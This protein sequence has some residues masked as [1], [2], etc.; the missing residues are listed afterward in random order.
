MQSPSGTQ[1]AGAPT[2]PLSRCQGG[3][4]AQQQSLCLAC[5]RSQVPS[6]ATSPQRKGPGRRGGEGREAQG[7]PEQTEPALRGPI[8]HKAA[9]QVRSPP[10][11]QEHPPPL[12]PQHQ[13]EALGPPSSPQERGPEEA[14]EAHRAPPCKKT[15]IPEEAPPPA[16]T[17]PRPGAETHSGQQQALLRQAALST[18][19]VGI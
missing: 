8:Q 1:P 5:R 12:A 4:T 14:G 13:G 17:P 11:P 19:K 18:L 15:S 2:D 3:A 9:S 16:L 6:P 7:Q 10:S